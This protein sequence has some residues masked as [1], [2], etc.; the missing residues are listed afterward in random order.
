MKLPVV[1]PRAPLELERGLLRDFGIKVV[2]WKS[3]ELGI[4]RYIREVEDV[5]Q[6]SCPE[7]LFEEFALIDALVPGPEVLGVEVDVQ[8]AQAGQAGDAVA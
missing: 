5:I 2:T 6:S 1:R 4:V 3:L 7:E 8:L